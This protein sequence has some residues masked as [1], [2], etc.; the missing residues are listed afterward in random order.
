MADQHASAHTISVRCVPRTVT[1]APMPS[2]GGGGGGGGARRARSSTRS[3]ATDERQRG[4]A[5]VQNIAVC[6]DS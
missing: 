6:D 3:P 1:V 4:G 2:G 5:A